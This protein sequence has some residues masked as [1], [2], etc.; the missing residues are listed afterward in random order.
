MKPR[1]DDWAAIAYVTSP[2]SDR[3]VL[4]RDKRPNGYL[5]WK[6]PG[7]M[8][9]P[10]ENT[11]EETVLRELREETG[12]VGVSTRLLCRQSRKNHDMFLFHVEVPNYDARVHIGADGEETSLF[13]ESEVRGGMPD[14]F[15]SH[16]PLLRHTG[17]LYQ[18]TAA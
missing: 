8:K 11:P 14:F 5:F 12:L 17:I 15:P 18:A 2:V 7:G 3:T 13:L 6:L 4:I 10:W 1:Q 9:E 16:L